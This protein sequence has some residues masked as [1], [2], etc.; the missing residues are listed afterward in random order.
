MHDAL[1][2][3]EPDKFVEEI[4]EWAP[5]EPIA[6]PRADTGD[7]AVHVQ[8]DDGWHREDVGAVETACD[9]HINARLVIDRRA[10][11]KVEHPLARCEC[12]TTK[13]RRYADDAYRKMFGRDF[14]YP[15]EK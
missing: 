8:L 5:T 3:Y 15:E 13:E 10:R 6:L 4:D 1:R 14:T 11:R 12:W 7:L 9:V 2:F